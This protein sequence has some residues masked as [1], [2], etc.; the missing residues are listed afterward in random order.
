M[1]ERSPF[2]L[3]HKLFLVVGNLM[4]LSY[5]GCQGLVSRADDW[6]A[7]D[8]PQFRGPN[9]GGISASAESLPVTF[10]ESKNVAW[11][12]VV[13]DGVG[14]P[15]VADG[16]AFVSGMTDSETVSLFAFDLES[17]EKL[18][19]RD[20]PAGNL[21][22]IHKTN[23]H[24]STTPAA[25][26]H[27]VY[28][29]FS[30]LGLLAVDAKTGED[31]WRKEL[32]VPFFVFKWGAGMSPVLYKDMV[33]FCQDDDLYPA[34]YAFD[35]E[36]GDLRWKDDREDMAVNY[37]HPI[38]CTVDGRD[39]I[40]V[41]GTGMLIGYD[42][43]SGERRWHAKVLLRNIKTTP[44]SVN[45]VIYLSVQSAGIANQWLASVDNAET[46]NNDG[47]LTKEEMQAFVGDT[48]I[49]EAFFRK[50]FDRGD[51]NKD[52]FLEGR[53]LD[54]AFLHP[55]NFAGAAFDTPQEN[56]SAQYIMA[57]QGGGEGDVTDTHVL[58][59]HATRHTDHIVSPFVS[60]GRM[61]LIKEGGVSTVFDLETGEPFR[62]AQR[63]GR[64][65]S[66]FASPIAGDGKI[67]IAS[68][69][70]TVLV[71]EDNEDYEELAT[72]DVGESIVGTP[73]ISQGNLLLRTRTKLICI[74]ERESL[75]G[76]VE[77]NRGLVAH[78]PLRGNGEDQSTFERS[79]RTQGT[80]DWNVAGPTG[81][82]RSASGFRGRDGWLEL[83]GSQAP[84]LGRAEFSISLW[85]HTLQRMDD[86]PGDLVSQYDA[87]RRRGFHVSLKTNAGVTTSQANF[88]H[89]HFGMDDDQETS[90]DDCGRPGNALLPFALTVYQGSLYAGTCEPGKDESGRV[91][92]YAGDQSWV[93]CGAPDASNSVTALAVH[94][95]ELYA[96]TGKYRV[97]GS[98]LPESENENLGGRVF[99]YDGEN[100][101]VDCG[102]IPEAEAVGGLVVFRDQLYA[103]SLY[104]PAGFYRY[105][106]GTRWI[107]CGTP[108]DRRVEALG[109][110]NGY[111]YATSYD[112][113]RVY[114]YDGQQW[115][116]C[117]QL[118]DNTQTYSFAVYEGKLYVGTWPSGRVYRF[119][120]IDQWT[121]VGR[122]GEE[123]EV[124]GMLVHNG[125]LT[126]GTLP[127]AEVY[128]YEGRSE[129]K[130][131][132][133]LDSTPDVK[134]RR[135]WTMAEFDGQLYCGTLPSGNVFKYEAGKNALFGNALSAG[136][137]HVVAVKRKDRLT[138][139]V[140][141]E[142]VAESSSFDPIDFDLDL[143]A[144]LKIGAGAND[145][146]NGR[147]SD[148]R[149]YQRS[150]NSEEIRQLAQPQP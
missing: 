45:G 78:W 148:V 128:S 136:W 119:E 55:D 37:S 72:N 28:F 138:L 12:H 30:T 6:H 15:V 24:A 114:R 36:T 108:D 69:N 41:A 141:G 117:G 150:L 124:M 88:R 19:Q 102:Q 145:V 58:W 34:L 65:G 123:L 26:E 70:G 84:R 75:T 50:T 20:W 103:S 7:D 129:W 56:T 76:A 38:V 53:E 113:G 106:G 89:L 144:P 115:T 59:R 90:W 2:L 101:W 21:P 10:S 16:R 149:I 98:A 60:Q 126:A 3:R 131:L 57:I 71:L 61:F 14:S 134:Y 125:R 8:W 127:L 96:A 44:V 18:W 143:N 81:V 109:V 111:V 48:P 49:P 97:A 68:E 99:R 22:E 77:L 9:S 4:L 83:P 95:G 137:H 130:L 63:V 132:R 104:R 93:D 27:R 92:R 1:R 120:D 85:L 142:L 23:S 73:A 54:I 87:S 51:L 139:H 86:I 62:N 140:D 32:P 64:G 107:N 13:G 147:I 122:L 42:P 110:F 66:Y 74:S 17:G 5:F 40:V 100:R 11:Q 133:Q 43:E 80:V 121:D 31:I 94:Q 146:F 29:Y 47:K 135:A 52:G 91:Y 33:L 118:G 35:K 82:A 39:E 112:G 79:L 46:G 25:D 67:Y 105:D 116:D